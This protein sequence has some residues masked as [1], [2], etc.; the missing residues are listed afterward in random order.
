MTSTVA[1]TA[2]A[3]TTTTC[4]HCGGK[5]LTWATSILNRSDV[6]QGR[7]NTR[8]VECVFYLGCD[9]CSETLALFSADRVA[10]LVNTQAAE[11]LAA[12]ETDAA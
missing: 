6:Q 3:F 1:K 5:A 8:D 2:Q 10:D 9:T 12:A 7:L 4:R 11:R